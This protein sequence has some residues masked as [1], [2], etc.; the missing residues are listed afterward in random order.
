MQ[1]LAIKIVKLYPKSKN[2]FSE[3]INA[4][5]KAEGL[6]NIL[7]FDFSFLTEEKIRLF[8]QIVNMKY[9]C[10]FNTDDLSIIGTHESY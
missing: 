2:T 7:G 5:L 9:Y 3:E 10:G 6:P 1:D 8:S 4:F